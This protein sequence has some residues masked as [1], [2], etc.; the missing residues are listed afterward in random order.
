MRWRAEN[1]QWIQIWFSSLVFANNGFRWWLRTSR[2]LH[3]KLRRADILYGGNT[4]WTADQ[5]RCNGKHQIWQLV[6]AQSASNST[7]VG[8]CDA[9][10]WT[11]KCVGKKRGDSS[12]NKYNIIYW[13]V[14]NSRHKVQSQFIC[15]SFRSN[16]LIELIQWNGNSVETQAQWRHGSLGRSIYRYY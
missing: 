11:I 15:F 13:L 1:I 12:S 9:I 8:R 10:A 3:T 7:D 16:F 4:W 2:Y 6:N 5:H 14:A